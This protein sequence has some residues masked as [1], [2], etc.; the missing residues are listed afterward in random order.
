MKSHIYER[1]SREWCVHD[2]HKSNYIGVLFTNVVNPA[3]G[4][5]SIDIAVEQM[6]G[7]AP[8]EIAESEGQ[9]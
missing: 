6:N 1:A 5:F 4:P 7:F 2:L 9:E 3:L 8:I